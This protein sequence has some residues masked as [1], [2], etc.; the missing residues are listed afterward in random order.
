M[1]H[2]AEFEQLLASNGVSLQELGLREVAL[3]QADALRAIEVLSASAIPIL[4][5]DVY[6]R[7]GQHV[8]PAYANW[9]ADPRPGET[10]ADFAVRSCK[11]SAKYVGGFPIRADV[12]PVFVLVIARGDS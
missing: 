9:H 1:N 5:G 7:R 2:A 4:G 12:T 3:L 8:E 11:H 10:R 6:F